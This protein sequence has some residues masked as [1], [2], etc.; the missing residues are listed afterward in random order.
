MSLPGKLGGHQLLTRMGERAKMARVLEQGEL[1]PGQAVWYH[2][3]EQLDAEGRPKVSGPREGMIMARNDEGTH[4]LVVFPAEA[5]DEGGRIVVSYP[6]GK[7]HVVVMEVMPIETRF[8]DKPL[9]SW[10]RQRA[11]K[12]SGVAQKR[13]HGADS[14]LTLRCY[15]DRNHA[16]AF[17]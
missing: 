16:A 12:R 13:M 14:E 10:P 7:Q 8:R 15:A 2:R 5:G 11:G 4:L 9:R 3:E 6:G 1:Q 17:C